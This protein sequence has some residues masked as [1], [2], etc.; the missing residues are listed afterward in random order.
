[1]AVLANTAGQWHALIDCYGQHHR[2]H[3]PFLSAE[4]Q[5]QTVNRLVPDMLWKGV[6]H[7]NNPALCFVG[8]PDQYYTFTMFYAQAQFVCGVVQGKVK[9]PAKEAMLADTLEWQAKEDE[10]SCLS[11][12]RN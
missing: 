10:V 1:M 12:S 9:I 4:L 5:L 7:P 8:M 3:F 6:V 11:L 2:H